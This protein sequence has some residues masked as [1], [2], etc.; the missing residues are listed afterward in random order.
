MTSSVLDYDLAAPGVHPVVEHAD[1]TLLHDLLEQLAKIEGDPGQMGVRTDAERIDQLRL[2]EQVKAAAAAAQA[3]ITV[4]L[5][6]STKNRI[7]P[8]RR[9][10]LRRKL[11]ESLQRTLQRFAYELAAER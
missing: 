9:W 11:A 4:E 7:P 10:W 5:D 6:F 2:L 1:V 3:R 8:A